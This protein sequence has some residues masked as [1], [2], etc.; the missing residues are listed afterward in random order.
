M[1]LQGLLQQRQERG[2]G[3][4]LEDEEAGPLDPELDVEGINR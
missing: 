3:T 1:A 2:H 4:G